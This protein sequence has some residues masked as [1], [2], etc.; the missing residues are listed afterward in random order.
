[1]TLNNNGTADVEVGSLYVS[2]FDAVFVKD[3]TTFDSCVIQGVNI[4]FW[5]EDEENV[6]ERINKMFDIL[7]EETIKAKNNKVVALA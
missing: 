7:F 5:M 3:K 4:T 6:G 2:C 1:M